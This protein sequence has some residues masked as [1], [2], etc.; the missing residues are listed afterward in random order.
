MLHLLYALQ[1]PG[2]KYLLCIVLLLTAQGKFS[3]SGHIISTFYMAY[4]YVFTYKMYLLFLLYLLQQANTDGFQP[5]QNI[6]VN[7]FVYVA[8]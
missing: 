1:Y 4:I 3:F 5:S 6:I 8:T 7:P 2:S